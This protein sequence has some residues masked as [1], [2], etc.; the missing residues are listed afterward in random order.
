[1][2]TRLTWNGT[3]AQKHVTAMAWRNLN[4]AAMILFTHIKAKVS[5]P[6]PA[7]SRAGNYPH[8]QV[9]SFR[10]SLTVD[11][12]RRKLRI[13]VGSSSILG[14]WLE[15][16]TRYMKRRPWMSKALRE[17]MGAMKRAMGRFA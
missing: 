3:A 9:G 14:F 11:H 8:K 1:M 16:G 6:G 4:K 2:A 15:L 12:N 7:P 10:G 5:L 13:R 17:K